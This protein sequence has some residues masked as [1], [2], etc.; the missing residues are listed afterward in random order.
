[1]RRGTHKLLLT[2]ERGDGAGFS[3]VAPVAEHGAGL[4]IVQQLG[5]ENPFQLGF[6]LWVV[7]G[8]GNLNPAQQISGHQVRRRDEVLGLFSPT[9]AVDAGVLQ[10]AA[11]NA[12]DVEALCFS[13]NS[14]PNTTDAPENQ[15][16]LYACLAG[17]LKL[18]D[19]GSLREGVCFDAD[20]SLMSQ[21]NLFI[22][23]V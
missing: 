17:L 1:M 4:H 21:D 2:V 8:A 19:D 18:V 11:H 23:V 7:D 12:G 20:I 10:I 5:A 9:K 13:G 16:Y 3:Q 6:Y 22:H 15:L 14:G